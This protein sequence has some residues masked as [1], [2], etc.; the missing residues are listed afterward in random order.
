MNRLAIVIPA[1]KSQFLEKT[2][3]ALA[4]QTSGKFNLYIGSDAGDKAIDGIVTAYQPSLRITYKR[5]TDNLGSTSLVQQWNRCLAMTEREEWLWV[6]PDDDVPDINGVAA[7]YQRLHDK[8][9]DVFRFSVRY[10]NEQDQVMKVAGALPAEQPSF[11]ALMEKLSFKRS[12]SLAEYIFRRQAFEQA[13]GFFELPLAW[14]TDDLLWFRLGFEKGIAGINDARVNIR[15]SAYNISNDY[16]RH[17]FDK[18]RANFLFM[19]VIV[20]SEEFNKLSEMDQS[21][22]KQTALNHILLNLRDFKMRLPAPK[23]FQYGLWGSRIWGGGIAKNIRRFY[24]NNQ[25]IRAR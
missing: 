21:R 14:G 13:G 6:L 1:Y 16:Q 3:A 5:F 10:V 9:A 7:F 18:V 25:R 22:F 2:L 20:Q 11:E 4:A 8:N 24:L 17:A 19:K 23:L 15:M 12:S